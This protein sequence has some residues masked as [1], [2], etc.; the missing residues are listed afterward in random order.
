MERLLITLSLA[1]CWSVS[2]ATYYVRT[3]GNDANAGTSDTAG[4][5]W[6][7]V[8]KAASTVAAGDTVYIRAGTYSEEVVLTTSGTAANPIRWIGERSGTNWTSIID[9]SIALSSGWAEDLSVGS[10]VYTNWTY[11]K[12]ADMLTLTNRRV[13]ALYSVAGISYPSWDTVTN[14]L[15]TPTDYTMT[16]NLAWSPPSP[17]NILWWDMV[18]VF[19]WQTKPAGAPSDA[20][21]TGPIYLRLRDGSD[22]SGMEFRVSN[23]RAEDRAAFVN[24][25]TT[26]SDTLRFDGA[27]YNIVSN[28]WL[29]GALSL[30]LLT[31]ADN[32]TIEQ[33]RFSHG[34][35]MLTI[36]G[37]S[38]TN[39]FRSNYFALE[40]HFGDVVEAD[41]FGATGGPQGLYPRRYLN[42][43]RD[44]VDSGIS[45]Y[46]WEARY[47]PRCI[48]LMG[49][50]S[51]NSI[52]GNA[53][54]NGAVALDIGGSS[55]ANMT[56]NTLVAFNTIQNFCHPGWLDQPF[57]YNT[58]TASNLI[59]NCDIGV[60]FLNWDQGYRT[61][62]FYGNRIGSAR[63]IGACVYWHIPPGAAAQTDFPTVW[64]Y[65]NSFSGGYRQFMLGST[66]TF[67]AKCDLRNVHFVNNIFS[68]TY[69]W[70]EMSTAMAEDA[71]NVGT[72]DYNYFYAAGNTF[73][74][75]AWYGASNV[76]A[77]AHIYANVDPITDWGSPSSAE[78]IGV[79]VNTLSLPGFDDP[80]FDNDAPDVG[81]IQY[82]TP[83]PDNPEPPPI[84][85]GTKATLGGAANIGGQWR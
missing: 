8:G 61:A 72:F 85:S 82:G 68:T 34:S 62:Y 32:N 5:A 53:M 23:M 49:N 1:L 63:N 24:G 55:S 69:L 51:N 29:R 19:W 50:G 9:K 28:I 77:S 70:T 6:L 36:V 27:D 60:R 17:T 20:A 42:Y 10:G 35:W 76:T 59:W 2:A 31:D 43:A 84:E 65:H 57:H 44:K 26:D 79:D 14:Y 38:S 30:A 4:G 66:A 54:E 39:M 22:P 33:C 45:R 75:A 47:A 18:D 74:T 58:V 40:R 83:N 71:D 52:I 37:T 48:R 25:V 12:W 15:M 11:A 56:T 21:P 64:F 81:W 67:P 78:E 3:N 73:P 41:H 16:V 46:Q 13:A 80:Y 7:T